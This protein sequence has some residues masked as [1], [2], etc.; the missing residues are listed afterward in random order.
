MLVCAFIC[1]YIYFFQA[2][3][4]I[5]TEVRCTTYLTSL[6]L[7]YPI[8]DI[9]INPMGVAVSMF[10][11]VSFVFLFLNTYIISYIRRYWLILVIVLMLLLSA[12]LSEDA[13]LSLLSVPRRLSMVIVFLA[14]ICAFSRSSEGYIEFCVERVFRLITFYVLVFGL[15]QVFYNPFFSLN[16][17]VWSK[18]VRISSCFFDPQLAG[19]CICICLM[20]HFSIFIEKKSMTRLLILCFLFYLGACTGSKVFLLGACSGLLV[21]F[22]LG[23]NKNVYVFSVLILSVLLSLFW[24]QI[25]ELSVFNRLLDAESSLASR[26]NVYWAYAINIFMDNPFSG[27]GCGM[28]QNY[29]MA[30]HIPLFHH[31]ETKVI[32]ASQP[33]SGYLLWLTEYGIL[34]F[35][36]LCAVLYVL[37]KGM[38]GRIINNSIVIPWIVSF[39]SVYNLFSAQLFL[40][41]MIVVAVI[42]LNRN[43]RKKH[44]NITINL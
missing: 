6:A 11:L 31:S 8:I 37:N 27:V 18:D 10:E 34:S 38:H 13:W 24:E 21:S 7:F 23:R 30:H 17:S 12:V 15:I 25:S 9:T 41:L 29:I 14:S 35:F 33:E 20:Y 42:L 39:A 16:Y 43:D 32:Y 22:F 44:E 36:L 2:V 3:T 5:R 40:L 19:C 26:Q 28:F 4:K 1:V